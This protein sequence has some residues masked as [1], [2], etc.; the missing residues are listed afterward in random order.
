MA[1]D[2]GGN[3]NKMSKKA[4]S[5]NFEFRDSRSKCSNMADKWNHF[6]NM[7]VIN[8]VVAAEEVVCERIN[9][10]NNVVVSQALIVLIKMVYGSVRQ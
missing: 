7:I 9:V 1:R 2:V 4:G 3:E 5:R 6:V 10:K 8:A